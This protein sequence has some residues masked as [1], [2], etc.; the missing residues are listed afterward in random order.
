LEGF[1][2]NEVG[3]L[4]VEFS[5][6]GAVGDCGFFLYAVCS[7]PLILNAPGCTIPNVSEARKREVA[8]HHRLH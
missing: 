4:S 3:A 5:T 8:T 6:D 2:D 7:D 1:G